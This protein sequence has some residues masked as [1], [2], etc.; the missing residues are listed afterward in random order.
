MSKAFVDSF[1]SFSG[2]INDFDIVFNASRLYGM[3]LTFLGVL[4]VPKL[5][6][7][8]GLSYPFIDVVTF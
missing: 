1:L 6:D 8:C 4:P 5:I 7:E 2:T 3:S